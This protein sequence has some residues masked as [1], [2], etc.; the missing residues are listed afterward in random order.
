[1]GLSKIE[2]MAQFIH[3]KYI[4]TRTFPGATDLWINTLIMLNDSTKNNGATWIYS[5][6]HK[7]AKKPTDK[8]FWNNAIQ[9]EGQKGD[10]LVFHGAIWHCAG[11]NSTQEARHII[12]PFFSRPFIKQQLDY[13]KAFGNEFGLICSNHLRQ[14]LGYNSRV[15]TSLLEFYQT[16]EN[17]FY[18]SDQG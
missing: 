13:P 11:K 12:T 18:Q 2:P 4:E 5:G 6:S 9:V 14:I 16:D 8:E 17:R 10:V 1:M 3:K 7:I 15:P